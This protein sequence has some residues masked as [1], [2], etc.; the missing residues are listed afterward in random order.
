MFNLE[1]LNFLLFIGAI[2]FTHKLYIESKHK[3]IL[4]SKRKIYM[5][6]YNRYGKKDTKGIR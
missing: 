6:K 2:Y 1:F 5:F 4:N 3:D